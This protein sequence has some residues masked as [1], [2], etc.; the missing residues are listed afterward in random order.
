M[1]HDYWHF[2]NNSSIAQTDDTA[3]VSLADTTG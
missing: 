3:A 1:T 2:G